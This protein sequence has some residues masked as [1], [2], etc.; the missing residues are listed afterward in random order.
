MYQ[1]IVVPIDGSST[2]WEAV[3]PAVG[4]AARWSCPVLV[5]SAVRHESEVEPARRDIESLVGAGGWH[6]LVAVRVGSERAVGGWVAGIV[7]EVPGSLVV[8]SST[9][10][11][12]S[13][14]ILGSVA[15]SILRRIDGP[16]L[17]YGPQAPRRTPGEGPIVVA[18]TGDEESEA[19]LEPAA[20]WAS[21]LDL[22]P[23]VVTVGEPD[24]PMPADSAEWGLASTMAERIRRHTGGPVEFETI[25]DDD[26]VD[27]LVRFAH[28][29]G[30]GLLVEVTHAR[31][32]LR[33]LR[34]GSV[35]MA[36]V[37]R[38]SC[39]VLVISAAAAVPSGE[40]IATE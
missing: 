28:D 21:A 13:A 34:R 10:R 12:R 35:T 39:P 17:V 36:C 31:T 14:A 6:D 7:A 29:L 26:P 27:A 22:V 38:A 9:G 25:R 33:R 3:V 16:A 37:H 4:L 30:A 15:E 18:V 2:A 23:W 1:R 5:V 32:G 8:L 40:A 11:G 20:E 19:A 24:Q